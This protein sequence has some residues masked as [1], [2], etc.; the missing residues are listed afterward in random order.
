MSKVKYPRVEPNI[1]VATYS[2]APTI[3]SYINP[4][5]WYFPKAKKGEHPSVYVGRVAR[6]MREWKGLTLKEA[7]ER[8]DI[9]YMSLWRIEKGKWQ[10]IKNTHQYLFDAYGLAMS[11]DFAPMTSPST[12]LSRMDGNDE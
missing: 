5:D 6:F 7:C 1:K 10:S 8:F 12:S 9:S 3:T 11:L 2:T 4:I